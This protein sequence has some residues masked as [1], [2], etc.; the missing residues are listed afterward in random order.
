MFRNGTDF[1]AICEQVWWAGL[2]ALPPYPENPDSIIPLLP[3]PPGFPEFSSLACWIP[4]GT[5]R[6]V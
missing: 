6:Y 1:L 4:Q 5:P 2:E 3:Y